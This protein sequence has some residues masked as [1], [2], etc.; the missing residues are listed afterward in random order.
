MRIQLIDLF[1]FLTAL[2]RARLAQRVSVEPI[3]RVAEDMNRSGGGSRC[4]SA[5]RLA[6]ATARATARWARWFGG[7]DTC[8]IRSLV[9][10]SMLADH[11]DV[12]LVI[13]FRPGVEE[14]AVDGHAWV[15]V[16]GR[17]VGPDGILAQDDYSKLI[18]VPFACGDLSKEPG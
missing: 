16:A 1:L 2:G 18:T 7:L 10:A 11:Q 3:T 8:L 6:L 12:A 15:T 14:A 9:L 13:G 5:D 4:Y 17:P